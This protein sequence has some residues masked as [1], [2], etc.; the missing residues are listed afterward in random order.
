ENDT[1]RENGR[2]HGVVVANDGHVL[3]FCQADPGVLVIDEN[4]RQVDAWGDRFAG[5]HGMTKVEEDGREYL[6]LTDEKSA[7]VVKTTL[8]GK[9]VQT[10]E[11]APHDAYRDGG[12][13]IPTWAAVNETRHGGNGDIWVADGYGSSL[14][15]RYD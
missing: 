7:E 1:T 13:Y 3:V 10:I 6:W 11:I 15:H 8:D 4:G 14:I 12:A 2:T 9:T 5:A